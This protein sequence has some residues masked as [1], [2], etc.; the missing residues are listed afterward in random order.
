MEY[1][2][3]FD[4]GEFRLDCQQRTLW[5]AGSEVPLSPRL[6]ETLLV[7]INQ[8]G[9][10]ISHEELLQTVWHGTLVEP[11]NLKVSISALR[12]ALGESA[13]TPK[14]IETIPRRG[15]RFVAPVTPILAN[16]N[17]PLVSPEPLVATPLNETI[18]TPEFTTLA[19]PPAVAASISESHPA[20]EQAQASPPNERPASPLRRRVLWGA[21]LILLLNAGV[22]FYLWRNTSRAASLAFPAP[23]ITKLTNTGNATHVAL[24]PNGQQVAYT[25]GEEAGTSLWLRPIGS[26]EA[27][28]LLPPSKGSFWGLSFAPNSAALYY[29]VEE[30]QADVGVLYQLPLP[31]GVPRRLLDHVNSEPSFSP[32]GR[33]MAFI[34]LS[35]A[36]GQSLLML[37]NSDG[38]GPRVLAARQLPQAFWCPAWSPDGTRI[39]AQALNLDASGKYSTLVSIPVTG[40]PEQ[41]IGTQRWQHVQGLQWLPTSKHLALAA[42]EV[43]TDGQQL[44]RISYP[45]G[46]AQRLTNDPALYNEPSL[47]ADGRLLAAVQR[48]TLDTIWVAPVE[49]LA[50]RRVAIRSGRINGVAWTPAGQLVYDS[51]ASGRQELWQLNLVNGQQQQ[52][53]NAANVRAMSAVGADGQTFFFTAQYTGRTQVWKLAQNDRQPMPL[54]QADDHFPQPTPDKEWVIYASYGARGWQLMKVPAA[55]GAPLALSAEEASDPD[56]SPDGRWLLYRFRNTQTKQWD[57][58]VRDLTAPAAPLRTFKPVAGSHSLLRWTPDGQAFTYFANANGQAQF[59]RQPLKGGSHQ[60]LFALPGEA[61]YAFAW[62]RDGKRLAYVTHLNRHDVVLLSQAN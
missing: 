56:V 2:R 27:V 7:L 26:A 38:S 16:G 49:D 45:H 51:N 61:V 32:D 46:E 57:I 25:L 50:A 39:A 55:G 3:F 36:E 34:R 47:G 23:S 8:R 30:A 37:A 18:P 40:G 48:E 28:R 17:Q 13:S 11:A 20:G 59:W 29:V 31:G 35:T 21:L 42:T 14:Y 43:G 60:M 58:G 53:T 33:Q 12:R 22:G 5:R 52:L 19:P 62:S 44:W 54:T 41:A 10:I 1:E 4:F 9:Q 24:A 15:Y 6:F